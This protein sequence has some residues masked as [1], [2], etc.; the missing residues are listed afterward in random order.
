M[1]YTVSILTDLGWDALA[2]AQSAK[3]LDFVHLEAGDGE[4][5]GGDTEMQGMT[6]LVHKVM[7]VPITSFSDDG[8]GQV[9][10]IGTLSSKNAPVGFDFRELGVKAT[11]D[12]G[13]ELL[14]TVS[15]NDLP[16]YIPPS[17]DI[18]TVIQTLEIICKIDRAPNVTINIQPG[19]DVTA[20]NIG[21]D[22]VGPGWFRDKIGNI[23]NFRRVISTS[24]T[25]SF[26]P[27]GDVV[28]F[29][30]FFPNIIPPGV[31]WDYAGDVPPVGGWLFSDGSLK[32][33]ADYPA[34]YA[35]IGIRH[36]G[37]GITTF[38][39]PDFRG[40]LSLGAG[41][42]TNDT[43]VRL[44]GQKG[45]TEGVILSIAQL[46]AHSHTASQPPHTHVVNDPAHAHTISDP[47]HGH[48]VYDPQHR[49]SEWSSASGDNVPGQHPP[50]GGVG[51]LAGT[52]DYYGGNDSPYDYTAYGVS[53]ISLYG[54]AT[55][56]GIYSSKTGITLQQAGNDAITVNSTGGGQSHNNMPPF[57]V[58]NKI[59]KI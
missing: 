50:M 14:Y 32:L 52:D 44:V 33:I 21:P 28:S 34:L 19:A 1:P 24:G 45:G 49:H 23:L 35:A 4:I 46:P 59:I 10:L 43:S 22:T 5:T 58:V 17:G 12:G 48:S 6:Q 37:D 42:A 16:D 13:P 26:T 18:A 53:R 9:T 41:A 7:D 56:I 15:Y 57:T 8:K 27:S 40:R 20:Q 11:I 25:V 30:V 54:S 3:V 2:D 36:G 51:Y 31:I 47:T 38:G 29:D 39:L 55:G